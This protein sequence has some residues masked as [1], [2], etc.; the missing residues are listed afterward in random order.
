MVISYEKA[1]I[2]VLYGI[3][4]YNLIFLLL[5][6]MFCYYC[7]PISSEDITVTTTVLTNQHL[8]AQS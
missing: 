4:Q 7:R 2:K 8:P 1:D 5:A 3:A 6:K